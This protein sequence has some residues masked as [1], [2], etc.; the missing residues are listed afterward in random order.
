MNKETACPELAVNVLAYTTEAAAARPW[1]IVTG[2]GPTPDDALRNLRRNAEGRAQQIFERLWRQTTPPDQQWRQK[3]AQL[4]DRLKASFDV[5]STRLVFGRIDDG[6]GWVA[7]GTLMTSAAGD[8]TDWL[9]SVAGQAS[10]D[11]S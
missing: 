3:I 4:G 1:G 7:Y 5:G 11:A 10:Q 6:P 8:G 9:E 2:T